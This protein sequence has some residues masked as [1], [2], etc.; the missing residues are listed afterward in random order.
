VMEEKTGEVR[1]GTLH[2]YKSEEKVVLYI[3]LV[4]LL[5]ACVRACVR[6]CGACVLA[7]GTCR[8]GKIGSRGAMI[9]TGLAVDDSRSQERLR[10]RMQ[11]LCYGGFWRFTCVARGEGGI[12]CFFERVN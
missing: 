7:C 10:M 9:Y 6:A 5:R 8:R 11:D 12:A 2:T 1:C 4:C 3:Q